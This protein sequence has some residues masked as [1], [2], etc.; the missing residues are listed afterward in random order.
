MKYYQDIPAVISN[1]DY[2]GQNPKEPGTVELYKA[3]SD[4]CLLAIKMSPTTGLFL[5]SFYT[6]NN[7]QKKVAGRLRTGRIYPFSFFK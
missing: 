4:H 3:M 6:L 1:P 7:G 5:G 2:A